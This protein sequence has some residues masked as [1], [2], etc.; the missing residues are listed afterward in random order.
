MYEV[1]V[2]GR[3]TGEVY[4]RHRLA[5]AAARDWAHLWPRSRVYVVPLG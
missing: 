2:N 5:A 3:A 1:H 4:N